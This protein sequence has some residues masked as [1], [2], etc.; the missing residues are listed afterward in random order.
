MDTLALLAVSALK[1]PSL[2]AAP[3]I[4]GLITAAL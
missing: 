4:S 3:H 1:T 2:Q